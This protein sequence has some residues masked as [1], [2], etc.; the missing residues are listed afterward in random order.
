MKP[1]APVTLT[2]T[3]A[4]AA[5]LSACGDGGASPEPDCTMT[6]TGEG[7]DPFL[8]CEYAAS[9]TQVRVSVN[10]GPYQDCWGLVINGYRDSRME[11]QAIVAT[12][13]FDPGVEPTAATYACSAG[14]A[15]PGTWDAKV[16][17]GTSSLTHR[18]Y[19]PDGTFGGVGDFSTTFTSVATTPSP[20]TPTHGALDATLVAVDGSGKTL[21]LHVEF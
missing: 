2:L 20:G 1:S 3:L 4:L 8:W 10:G 15:D 12:L 9:P 11:D 14:G 17:R 5:L 13:I 6:L 19:S 18:M 21:A 7:A 16:M